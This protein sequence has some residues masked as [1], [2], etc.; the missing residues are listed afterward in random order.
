MTDLN[1]HQPA[2][3]A[4]LE[5]LKRTRGFDFAAYK[6]SSLIRRINKRLQTIGIEN[7]G[8]YVDYLEV[9]PEEFA[10][11][12]N[13]ILINVTG[14]FRDSSAW[15]FLAQEVIPRLIGAKKPG[16][17]I[18]IWSAGCASGEEAYTVAIIL[19]EALGTEEFRQRVKIYATDADEEALNEARQASYSAN[20]IKDVPAELVQKYFEQV[21]SRYIFHKD[22]RRS[23]IFGRHDL[24]Q[25]APISRVDLILCRNTLMYFN[26]EAQSKVLN[27]FDF[28][29]NGGGYL[30][31]GKAEVLLTRS[32]AF[33]PVDLKRHIFAKI[34]KS[35]LRERFL[36][37]PLNPP[38][39]V[40]A[41]IIDDN[42]LRE[43]AL[44]VGPVAQLVVDSRWVLV[45]ANDQARHLFNITSADLGRRLQDL[46]LSYR[47]LDLRSLL[48][49]VFTERRP[50]IVKEVN[51]PSHNNLKRYLDVLALPLQDSDG[52]LIGAKI[53]FEDVSHIRQLREEL[54]KWRQEVETTNEELQAS[55]E[56]LETTNEELQSTVEELETTNEELQS[57]NEE[58]ETM[59]EE[60]QST[61][62]E[63][64]TT[65][66][67]LRQRSDELNQVN[68]FFESI[69]TSLP[70]G[71]VVVDRNMQ[72]LAWNLRAEDLWG[73]RADEVRGKHLLN[74]DI[75][76]PVDRLKVPIRHCLGGSSQPENQEVTLDAVNRRGKSIQVKV[77]CTP[78]VGSNKNIQGAILL[79]EEKRAEDK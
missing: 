15:G 7:Y 22:L 44:E 6:R 4:L 59:N 51:W 11:L 58:L 52:H 43:V 78:L 75:G 23:V 73:L 74:L 64:E 46:E 10:Q 16:E 18:R 29:L 54:D 45:V 62:E 13:T 69:L 34:S 30:F 76:L 53:A 24:I 26:A 56:E 39:E 63:L 61:N 70:D 50:Q 20:Q 28:A 27:H 40:A 35:R 48:D 37:A 12:F 32:N 2:F 47:P 19:A 67:E 38:E 17:P 66:E 60:L 21:N 57:T 33:T 71:V 25:D 31:L 79:M 41:Q 68:A 55:N 14:F 1:T 65:N 5:Y 8:D 9:H 77:S 36:V 3:E 42:R 49:R 72:I